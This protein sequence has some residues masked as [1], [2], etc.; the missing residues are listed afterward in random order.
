M[1]KYEI[2]VLDPKLTSD[3]V[4]NKERL[5]DFLFFGPQD[6]VVPFDNM[7]ICPWQFLPGQAFATPYL[8]L[9]LRHITNSTVFEFVSIPLCL[10]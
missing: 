7:N 4:H 1:K 5:Y 6:Y 3:K 2:I 8:R 10:G 9:V